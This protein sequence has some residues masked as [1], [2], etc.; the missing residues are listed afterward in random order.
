TFLIIA[1]MRSGSVRTIALVLAGAVL[2]VFVILAVKPYVL[3]RFLGWGHVWDHINDEYGYQQ[4]RTLT[5]IASGG[6]FGLG[7]GDSYLA[8]VFAAD[9]DLVFG[10]L[11]EQQ[12][13]L[14]GL[15]VLL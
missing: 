5:Y 12:G 6:L 11:C 8:S 7:L 13:L 4:T 1:F 9:S 15:V 10:L 3:D 14:L 2:A